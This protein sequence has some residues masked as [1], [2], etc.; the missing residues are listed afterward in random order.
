M[1]K[2]LENKTLRRTVC[3]QETGTNRRMKKTVLRKALCFIICIV[4]KIQVIIND[5]GDNKIMYFLNG[6]QI[7]KDETNGTCSTMQ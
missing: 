5:S 7:N 4:H 1:L 2:A 3:T 6:D